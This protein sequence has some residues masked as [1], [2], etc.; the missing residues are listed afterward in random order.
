MSVGLSLIELVEYTDWERGKWHD[1][2][3]QHGDGAL[4]ISAG[5]HGDGRFQTI[6]DQVRHIFSAERRYVDRLSNRP[7]TDTTSL[8]NSKCRSTLSIWSAKPNRVEGTHKNVSYQGLGC[9]TG[10]QAAELFLES[11]T[12]EDRYPRVVARNSS[13]GA[14]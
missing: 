7:L 5:P 1:W 2:L 10:F 11:L 14:G 13:L 12:S 3:L 6:G 4:A 9:P 8:P